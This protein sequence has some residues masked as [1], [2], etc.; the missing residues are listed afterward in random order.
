MTRSDSVHVFEGSAENVISISSYIETADLFSN[1]PLSKGFKDQLTTIVF[2]LVS[3][4]CS[5]MD[6][7]GIPLRIS[8]KLANSWYQA[9]DAYTFWDYNESITLRDSYLIPHEALETILTV[10]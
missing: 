2:L 4:G 5:S 8:S 6:C 7:V 1:R 3:T 9:L 10:W